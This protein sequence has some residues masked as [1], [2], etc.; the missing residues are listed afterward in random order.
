MKQNLIPPKNHV[1]YSKDKDATADVDKVT[2]SKN[3]H[4]T[5]EVGFLP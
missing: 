5:I 2:K 4:Q 1:G 3:A